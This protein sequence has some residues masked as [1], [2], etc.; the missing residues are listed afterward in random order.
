MSCASQLEG[1]VTHVFGAEKYRDELGVFSLRLIQLR[2]DDEAFPLGAF[3]FGS[4]RFAL[5]TLFVFL[6]ANYE[7]ELG[8]L[9]LIAAP[10]RPAFG[11]WEQ[12][13]VNAAI[14]AVVAQAFAE[15]PGAVFVLWRIVAVADERSHGCILR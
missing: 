4:G 12:V 14:N 13:L 9:N 11:G 6:G 10:A 8:F 1:N 7:N 5:V 15:V 3:A 2:S